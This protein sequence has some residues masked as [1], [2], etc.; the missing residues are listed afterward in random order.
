MLI[1]S[2]LSALLAA[3]AHADPFS[4]L[5][6][7]TAPPW[8]SPA[9]DPRSPAEAKKDSD[10]EGAYE[11]A[12]AARLPADL[13]DALAWR[14]E[15][16]SLLRYAAS[17]PQVF[18]KGPLQRAELFDEYRA[19]AQSSWA[20]A[21]DLVL[22]LDRLS[23]LYGPARAS[24]DP[25]ARRSAQAMTALLC[26]VRARFVRSWSVYAERDGALKTLFDAPQPGLGLSSGTW[27]RLAGLSTG[28]GGRREAD[29]AR[30][31][32]DSSGGARAFKA[33]GRLGPDL[34]RSAAAAAAADL[35]ALMAR[36]ARRGAPAPRT[37]LGPV[38]SHR[39]LSAVLEA[40]AP[41]RPALP[42]MP[43]VPEGTV[44]VSSRVAYAVG[45]FRHWFQ[46]DASTDAA[47][48]D[49]GQVRTLAEALR[50]GDILLARGRGSR[51]AVGQGGWWDAAGLYA[52]SDGE[53]RSAFGDDALSAALRA[54][55]PAM[56]VLST[57]T[58]LED[59]PTV[60][61][62]SRDGV[63]ARSLAAFCAAEAVV[64]L[65]PLVPEAAKSAALLG[66]AR[67]VGRP[68]DPAQDPAEAARVSE[69]EL[70][71][72]AYEGALAFEE[73]P[74]GGRRAASPGGV[75]RAYDARFG[76]PGQ[77]LEFVAGIGPGGPSQDRRLS[78]E[79]FRESARRR[80]WD[81][82]E[83]EEKAP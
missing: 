10:P 54:A 65:R 15:L 68:Y 72:L 39:G 17:R 76:T 71:A 64:A 52:G 8:E 30:A 12:L 41:E 83:P 53:R 43:P 29:A 20:R 38:F 49:R 51:G 73:E 60:V 35:K 46:L 63:A 57:M 19:D 13:S 27:S 37:S 2:V 42:V 25:A 6:I 7:P 36:P 31:A 58:A 22:A 82:A 28:D 23:A 34:R 47:V 79:R 24:K 14:G 9:G 4:E 18:P 33:A 3:G 11:V 5:G 16:A 48:P 62:A 78:I 32:W 74:A 55:A 56:T 44:T 61:S 40:E 45:T 70:L 77:R 66:A 1:V 80:R 81:L 59:L 50:P 21:L 26:A 69:G 67:L 75:A